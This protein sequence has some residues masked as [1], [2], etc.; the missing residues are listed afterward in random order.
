M[1]SLK[2][3]FDKIYCP[4]K[5]NI[6]GLSNNGISENFPT[7]PPLSLYGNSKIISEKLVNPK[8]YKGQNP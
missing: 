6:N 4:V 5:N 8:K 1:S 7:S 3:K 2:L